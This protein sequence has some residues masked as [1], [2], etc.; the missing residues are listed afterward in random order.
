VSP[1]PR[2]VDYFLFFCLFFHWLIHRIT[3]VATA[4]VGSQLIQLFYG[5]GNWV[6]HS[7]RIIR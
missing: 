4:F 3:S 5:L 7:S 6:I 2:L 1:V